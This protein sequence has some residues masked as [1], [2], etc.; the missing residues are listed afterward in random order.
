[1]YY[2]KMVIICVYQS[3]AFTFIGKSS[4]QFRHHFPRV[5][6]LLLVAYDV[7]VTIIKSFDDRMEFVSIIWCVDTTF[8]RL[9]ISSS[10]GPLS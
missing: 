4:H 1:M 9:L 2:H 7:R 8:E 10:S 6:L 3:R 5:C